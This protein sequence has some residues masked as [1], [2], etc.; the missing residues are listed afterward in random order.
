MSQRRAPGEQPPEERVNNFEEVFGGY[1]REEAIEEAKRCLQCRKPRCMEG[2]PV[3]IP[4]ADF[5]RA[6]KEDDLEKAN[7]IIKESNFLPSITGR[8]C[9]QEEQCEGWCVQR[10][11]G[12]SVAIGRLERFVAD[13]ARENVK[14]RPSIGER[15]EK[16]VAV[17]GSG[18]AGLTCA[19]YLGTLG[20]RVKIFEA[21]H[22]PGGV[23]TYGIPDFRLPNR[24]V[25]SEIDYV[26]S[27]GVEIET[28]VLIG[29]TFSIEDLFQEGYSAIF[30]G[31]GAGLPKFLGLQG[32]N[33][34]GIYSAN[35]FLFR[36]VFMKGHR[37][38]EYDTPVKVGE[39]V[40]VIGG[41]NVA[42]DSARVA[43]RMGAEV[44]IVY[45]RSENELPARRE[46]IVHAKEEGVKFEFLTT[47]L[48]F[49]GDE[50]AI[51]KIR[52]QRMELGEPDSSGRRKPEP[53]EGSEFWMEA[54]NVIMAIG[55]V[56]N[57]LV[58]M[59][60]GGLETTKWGTM[61]VDE[62][63]R[64][65]IPGVFAGGDSTTGQATVISAMGQGKLAGRAIHRYLERCD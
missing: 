59:D 17:V 62:R 9:P 60:T 50:G 43:L 7:A 61:V 54:D 49:H 6:I 26:K 13:W 1:T 34:S 40:A 57:P 5:I 46:E 10:A 31:T 53:V 24:V 15:R 4:I 47:P 63:G 27:L 32:E 64:T 58:P 11:R 39:S 55:Q 20:Y 33:L 38:P 8:V 25:H 65:T 21:L 35:E 19:A 48:S 52:C 45:R 37:F 18:P 23:L 44:S 12:E 36:T 41:G 22:E 28:D 30:L 29:K 42:L 51:R 16:K 56:P 14:G 3:G 2:C